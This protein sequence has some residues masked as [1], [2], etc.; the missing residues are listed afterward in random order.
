MLE[1]ERLLKELV[2]VE[3]DMQINHDVINKLCQQ[4]ARGD[5]IVSSTLDKALESLL[6][7]ASL[8]QCR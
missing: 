5:E 8:G 4:V 6:K 3:G 7:R 2:D 1:L